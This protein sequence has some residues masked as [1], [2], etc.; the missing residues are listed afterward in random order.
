MLVV[1][2]SK[3][4]RTRWIPLH[5]T[6]RNALQVY[7]RKRQH[8]FPLADHFFT[9]DRGRRLGYQAARKVFAKLR[10]QL[11][12]EG[13][14]PRI[15]DFRHAFACRVLQRWQAQRKGAQSRVIILSRYLGHS[16]IT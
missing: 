11:A 10:K 7:S 16:R 2:E 1:R 6:A 8:L 15:H 13:R 3:F 9:S 14:Q 12:V 5:C 4:R